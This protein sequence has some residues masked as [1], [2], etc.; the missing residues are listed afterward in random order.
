MYSAC[1]E[2]EKK[3]ELEV[4]KMLFEI[5]IFCCACKAGEKKDE[6][7]VAKMLF[8]IDIFCCS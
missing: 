3:D 8:D 7:E 5:D 1:K 6:L 2:G 4:A